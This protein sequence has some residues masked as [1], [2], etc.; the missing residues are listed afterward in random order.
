MIM[1][2]LAVQCLDS[3]FVRFEPASNATCGE[4]A[5]EW[6]ASTKGYLANP[7]ALGDCRYCQY[8][9]GQDVSFIISYP[10]IFKDLNNCID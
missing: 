5:Q 7:D 8:S 2:N 9:S 4:Y 1:S 6:L 10:H 3:E